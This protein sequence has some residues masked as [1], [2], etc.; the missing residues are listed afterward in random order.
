MKNQKPKDSLVNTW[1]KQEQE[2]G[3]VQEQENDKTTRERIQGIDPQISESKN[4]SS[5]KD[6]QSLDKR[7]I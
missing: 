7:D 3:Q 1:L 5:G 6:E 4:S 2:Q